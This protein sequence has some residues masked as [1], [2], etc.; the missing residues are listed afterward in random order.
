MTTTKFTIN[1]DKVKENFEKLLKICAVPMAMHAQKEDGR[2]NN[3]KAHPIKFTLKEGT[4][5]ICQGLH[6][7]SSLVKLFG[8][9][10]MVRGVKSI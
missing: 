2:R 6:S 7:R 5:F 3:D 8:K 1:T 9:S 10:A 4:T